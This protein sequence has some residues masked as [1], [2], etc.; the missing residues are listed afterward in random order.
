MSCID[1]LATLTTE[2]D[3]RNASLLRE[4]PYCGPRFESKVLPF[5]LDLAKD[6][7]TSEYDETLGL[8]AFMWS[9]ERNACLYRPSSSSATPITP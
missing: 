8:S 7:W 6:S 2:Q 4:T 3:A 5:T 1:P 9:N